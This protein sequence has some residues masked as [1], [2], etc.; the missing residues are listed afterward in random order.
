MDVAIR[1]CTGGPTSRASACRRRPTTRCRGGAK[2]ARAHISRQVLQ[3]A[4]AVAN[5]DA[6]LLNVLELE[7][8][9]RKRLVWPPILTRSNAADLRRAIPV[10]HPNR[11]GEN[12]E[13]LRLE[14][15]R[16]KRG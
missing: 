9:G 4:A 2:Q 5:N 10:L 1:A 7:G 3:L 16:I 15:A 8:S 11:A 6:S 14:R 12:S 13:P